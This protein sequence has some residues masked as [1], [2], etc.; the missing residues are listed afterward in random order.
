MA[1]TKVNYTADMVDTAKTFYGENGN[2]G[3]AELAV[4]LGRSVRSVRA[5]LVREGVY[6]ADVKQTPTPKDDGP[7][8]AELLE[9]IEATGFDTEGLKG[10]TSAAL[11]RV[12]A[13]LSV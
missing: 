9:A 3:M 13:V 5:K 11:A 8:K 10:A 4:L 7:T 1:D 6:V 2:E 12:L